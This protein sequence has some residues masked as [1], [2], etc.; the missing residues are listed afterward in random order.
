MGVAVFA[1]MVVA[2][3]VENGVFEGMLVKV[4]VNVCV[5]VGAAVEV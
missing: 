5:A 3:L 2:V 1:G 4:A